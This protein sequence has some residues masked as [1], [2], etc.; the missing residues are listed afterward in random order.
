MAF[1][2]LPHDGLGSSST[3]CSNIRS[4]HQEILVGKPASIEFSIPSGMPS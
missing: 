3:Q 1:I 4:Q 2:I